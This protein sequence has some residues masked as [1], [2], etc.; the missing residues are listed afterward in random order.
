ML[1]HRRQKPSVVSIPSLLALLGPS[2][3]LD[4][5]RTFKATLESSAGALARPTRPSGDAP[6]RTVR[7]AL[8]FRSAPLLP[9]ATPAGVHRSAAPAE[10]SPAADA[11]RP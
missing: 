11:P 3:V 8:I 1:L 7:V 10:A 5:A 2:C 9:G 6:T 4:G